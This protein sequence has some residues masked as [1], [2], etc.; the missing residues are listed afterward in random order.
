MLL[1]FDHSV[2][3]AYGNIYYR[4]RQYELAIRSYEDSLKL[5]QFTKPIHPIVIAI[6]YSLGCV[7]FDMNLRDVAK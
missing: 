4:R 1:I 7:A 3:Y 2:Y 5:C 6:Y